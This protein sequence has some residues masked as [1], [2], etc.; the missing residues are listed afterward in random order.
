VPWG[1]KIS[2]KS[3]VPHPLASEAKLRETI[4]SPDA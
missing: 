3:P 2:V 4:I 1:C